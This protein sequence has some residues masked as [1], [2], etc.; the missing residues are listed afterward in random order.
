MDFRILGPLEVVQEG[1]SLPLGAAKQRAL[2]AILVLH[3]NQVVSVDRLIDLLWGEDPP[4]TAPNTLQVYVSGL[5]K[6]LEPARSRGA[7]GS[8][9]VRRPPG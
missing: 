8:L 3:A 5:R 6:V 7:P 9:I 4:E 1:R 2:L